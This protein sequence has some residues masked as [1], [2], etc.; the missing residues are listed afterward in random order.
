MCQLLLTLIVAWKKT[1]AMIFSIFK[2]KKALFE[3][4]KIEYPDCS[5]PKFRYRT[6]LLRGV[7]PNYEFVVKEV[8]YNHPQ[9][10]I[11]WKPDL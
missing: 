8:F 3:A 5:R 7:L 9:Y 1:S 4:S 11:F 2:Q 6:L 10:G